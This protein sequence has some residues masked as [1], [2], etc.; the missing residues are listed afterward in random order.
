VSKEKSK[1]TRGSEATTPGT[2]GTQQLIV[3]SRL[4]SAAF[5]RGEYG[6]THVPQLHQQ[7]I[8]HMLQHKVH[9]TINACT[10]HGMQSNKSSSICKPGKKPA[11]VVVV[12]CPA[13]EQR[14]YTPSL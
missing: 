6:A 3:G 4:M 5:V 2:Q 9:T 1:L 10:Y 7:K 8:F 14:C 12:E 11:I 13:L